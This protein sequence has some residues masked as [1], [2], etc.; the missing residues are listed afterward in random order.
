MNIAV[1]QAGGMGVRLAPMQ[2]VMCSTEVTG[3]A[4][5]PRC[6]DGWVGKAY[7]YA[8]QRGLVP[9][10]FWQKWTG[11]DTVVNPFRYLQILAFLKIILISPPSDHFS[12][13]HRQR[14]CRGPDL[15]G[16][17]AVKQHGLQ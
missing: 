12:P 1:Q 5:Q 6:K 2:P 4:S 14:I 3:N 11:D 7:R 16:T 17:G 13:S 15:S 8:A 9:D 10:A